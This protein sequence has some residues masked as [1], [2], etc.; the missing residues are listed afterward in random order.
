MQKCQAYVCAYGITLTS[1]TG[2]CPVSAM[3]NWH[4]TYA[5]LTFYD[6]PKLPI[7][8][9]C[10]DGILYF[11][12][13]LPLCYLINE[14]HSV[15]AL[16]YIWFPVRACFRRF[17]PGIPGVLGFD[18]NERPVIKSIQGHVIYSVTSYQLY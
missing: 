13:Y 3:L 8:Y 2:T 17:F 18:E 4:H 11:W 14:S 9:V 12:R 16:T 5:E 10:N 6:P 7:Y 1:L 15:P